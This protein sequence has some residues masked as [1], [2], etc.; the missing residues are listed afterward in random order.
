MLV[1]RAHYPF[2]LQPRAP[3]RTAGGRRVGG[4]STE[5]G[6]VQRPP[7]NARNNA[8][9][10]GDRAATRG[11]IATEG[12]D[13]RAG[14][15]RRYPFALKPGCR[16]ARRRRISERPRRTTRPGTRTLVDGHA[17]RGDYMR[18]VFRKAA[19]TIVRDDAPLIG[20]RAA[21]RRRIATKG[22]AERQCEDAPHL[23]S[24]PAR[25]RR[26][27]R[28]AAHRR[29]RRHARA[30]RNGRWRRGR[31][32]AQQNSANRRFRPLHFC[33]IVFGSPHRERAATRG[34]SAREVVMSRPGSPTAYRQSAFFDSA[35]LQHYATEAARARSSYAYPP[36]SP[37]MVA[38]VG[39]RAAT[40][41]RGR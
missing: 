38:A 2:E 15:T 31:P 19:A 27:Q 29:T 26:R 14:A 36:W 4:Y 40:R 37:A 41:G 20:E 24:E 28:R 5:W 16:S 34:R 25:L 17:T 18:F 10:T 39:E 1:R 35:F 33:N 21:M 32:G 13:E 6:D 3:D 30:Q 11:R 8:S 7:S 22:G 12:G 23:A 9:L